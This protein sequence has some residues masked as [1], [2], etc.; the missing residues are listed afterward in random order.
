M[1]WRVWDWVWSAGAEGFVSGG[2]PLPDGSRHTPP[3]SYEMYRL[4]F[5]AGLRQSPGYEC[6]RAHTRDGHPPFEPCSCGIEAWSDSAFQLGV[7][8]GKA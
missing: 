7:L 4:G 6:G 2:Q 5:E 8:E 3:T 1:N